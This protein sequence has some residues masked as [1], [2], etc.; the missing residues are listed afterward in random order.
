MTVLPPEPVVETQLETRLEKAL[1]KRRPPASTAAIATTPLPDE[2]IFPCLYDLGK[3]QT[4]FRGFMVDGKDLVT[5]AKESGTPLMTVLHW[6]NVGDW[7]GRRQQLIRVQE[8]DEAQ[9]ISRMRMGVRR[10]E[11]VEQINTGTRLREA[12]NDM[13]DGAESADAIKKLSEAAKAAGDL[14]T[15]AMGVTADG[16]TDSEAA[17]A[18]AA[19]G[20]PSLV[21]VIPGGGLPSVRMAGEEK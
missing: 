14:S 18:T 13:I 2:D 5:A 9:Q 1:E 10:T 11:L 4:V 7:V 8:K 20:R 15:R 17:A 6:A 21:V 12:V 19:S 16:A 3:Q